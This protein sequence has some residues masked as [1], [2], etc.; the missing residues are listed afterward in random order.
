MSFA[1]LPDE[2]LRRILELLPVGLV[3]LYAEVN[4]RWARLVAAHLASVGWPL[5]HVTLASRFRSPALYWLAVQRRPDPLA[6]CAS[7]GH[8]ALNALSDGNVPAAEALAMLD[9]HMGKTPPDDW[10]DGRTWLRHNLLYALFSSAVAQTWLKQMLDLV[11]CVPETLQRGYLYSEMRYD[12]SWANV[13]AAFGLE[14]TPEQLRESL[15]GLD[16]PAAIDNDSSLSACMADICMYSSV[17]VLKAAMAKFPIETHGPVADRWLRYCVHHSGRPASVSLLSVLLDHGLR[18]S[19]PATSKLPLYAWSFL[20]WAGLLR[21]VSLL[22]EDAPGISGHITGAAYGLFVAN[23]SPTLDEL[24]RYR[25]L[26]GRLSM[27]LV[28]TAV[29]VCFACRPECIEWLLANIS[30]RE[31][32]TGELR[33]GT[34]ESRHYALLNMSMR[35]LVADALTP[36]RACPERYYPLHTQKR[37][38]RLLAQIHAARAAGP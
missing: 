15:F 20:S 37:R 10:A 19:A 23:Q 17:R 32:A 35:W 25:M 38:A 24:V 1:Q 31:L 36:N 29:S 22:P 27:R 28:Y 9:D 6:R 8:P 26:G 4:R 21:W 34:M 16:D 7:V 30:A 12:R 14:P 13:T 18:L 33:F 2:T 11:G 3:P 5:P